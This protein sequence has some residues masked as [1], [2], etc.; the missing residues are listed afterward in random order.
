[1]TTTQTSVR[2]VPRTPL[3]EAVAREVREWIPRAAR[4]DAPRLRRRAGHG[5]G[6]IRE[7][8]P[9]LEALAAATAVVPKEL[10]PLLA[11]IRANL[12]EPGFTVAEL[13]RRLGLVDKELLVHFTA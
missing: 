6:L 2:P 9:T 10:R 8:R 13:E 4:V 12:F 3:P 11:E 5:G 7:A 1:M